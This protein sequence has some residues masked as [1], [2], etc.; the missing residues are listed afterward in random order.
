MLLRALVALVALA[1][2]ATVLLG[3]AGSG[4]GDV[5]PASVA[6]DWTS[7]LDGELAQA[8][9]DLQRRWH[10]RGQELHVVWAGTRGQVYEIERGPS[11]E[12]VRKKVTALLT[13]AVPGA[14]RC[15]LHDEAALSRDHLGGGQYGPPS[16]RGGDLLDLDGKPRGRELACGDVAKAKGGAHAPFPAAVETRAAILR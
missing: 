1:A 5:R 14:G 3:C 8:A 11:G 9:A 4:P 12:P 7:P 6:A 16:I 15:Y 2:A 13:F 10:A